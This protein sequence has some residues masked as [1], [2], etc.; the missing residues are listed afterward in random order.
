M[1][2]N[3]DGRR[4]RY[5]TDIGWDI[6]AVELAKKSIPLFASESA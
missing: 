2:C 4:E 6:N 3:F 1:L 5:F